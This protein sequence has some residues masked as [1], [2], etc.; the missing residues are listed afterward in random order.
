MPLPGYGL[1]HEDGSEKDEF[2]RKLHE[3]VRNNILHRTDSYIKAANKGRKKVVFQPGDLV[4]IHLRKERFPTQ[5][6][7][8]LLPRGD[9]PFKVISRINDN[10]Y[11]VDL[12]GKYGVSNSFNVSDLSSFISDAA[13]P[14]NSRTNSFEEGGHEKE[15]DARR[16]ENEI[17]GT[18]SDLFSQL[19]GP[20]TRSM[21]E[22]LQISIDS[23]LGQIWAQEIEN[24][25]EHD[26]KLISTVTTFQEPN[27]R[28]N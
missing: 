15:L 22:K 24:P 21:S 5:R 8:K 18:N 25:R 14:I 12:E 9:G 23:L 16:E 3:Q 10:A 7:S 11:T 4:W 2:V 28:S 17:K 19:H 6:K 26:P 1:N 27:F 13:E 20:I